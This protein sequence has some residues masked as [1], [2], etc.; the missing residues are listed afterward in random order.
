MFACIKHKVVRIMTHVCTRRNV[1]SSRLLVQITIVGTTYN[2]TMYPKRKL[3]KKW[4]LCDFIVILWLCEILNCSVF[5]ICTVGDTLWQWGGLTTRG[6]KGLRSS[7]CLI[8]KDPEMRINRSRSSHLSAYIYTQTRRYKEKK[9]KNIYSYM[10]THTH[11]LCA[12]SVFFSPIARLAN[13]REQSVRCQES[14]SGT[15]II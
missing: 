1:S 10:P 4:A 3:H 9:W 5:C 13:K 7:V 8:A 12:I 14:F 11:I 2:I 6:K 15:L